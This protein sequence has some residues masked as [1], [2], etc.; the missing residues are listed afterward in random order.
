M[1]NAVTQ[2]NH[3][4]AEE[5]MLPTTFLGH[6]DEGKATIFAQDRAFFPF[7]CLYFE[8]LNIL[9]YFTVNTNQMA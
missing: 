1:T 9:S 4:P 3:N 8:K 2:G 7:P 5:K 6:E